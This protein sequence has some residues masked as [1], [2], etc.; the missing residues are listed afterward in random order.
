MS[1][2]YFVIDFIYQNTCGFCEWSQYGW[3]CVSF[4][5]LAIINLRGKTK[6]FFGFVFAK[7]YLIWRL[8]C[9]HIDK[10]SWIM[11]NCTNGFC[12]QL[13]AI[14]RR[15]QIMHIIYDLCCQLYRFCQNVTIQDFAH[16][17]LRSV[18]V[19]FSDF[20]R[21][22]TLFFFCSFLISKPLNLNIVV[23]W[24]FGAPL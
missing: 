14:E 16:S 17:P 15:S 24:R 11:Y 19:S 23:E 8:F 20:A 1:R 5:A 7:D 21:W 13:L 2:R 18:V 22:S 12:C 3:F 4:P 6:N 10:Y 9:T